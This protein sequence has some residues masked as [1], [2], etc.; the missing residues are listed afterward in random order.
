RASAIRAS[1]YFDV[2]ARRAS[3]G[4]FVI[5]GSTPSGVE[6]SPP[7][8]P[9]LYRRSSTILGVVAEHDRP[10]SHLP[11]SHQSGDDVRISSRKAFGDASIRGTEDQQSAIGRLRERS[12]QD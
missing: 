5:A 12:S 7:R 6:P 10:R 11:S 1:L 3:T 2:A 8:P 9:R 4:S